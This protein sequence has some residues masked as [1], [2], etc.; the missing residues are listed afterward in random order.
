MR[1]RYVQGQNIV[2]YDQT[3]NTLFLLSR[4]KKPNRWQF[5]KQNTDVV[6]VTCGIRLY[7]AYVSHSAPVTR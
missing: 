4:N 3:A 5:R 2:P 6:G 7:Y 1:A